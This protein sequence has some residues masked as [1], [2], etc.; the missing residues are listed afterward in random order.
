MTTAI[1]SK[2]SGG[3]IFNTKLHEFLKKNTETVSLEIV[4]NIDK[5]HFDVETIYIVDGILIAENINYDRLKKFKI[6][7][8]IHLW[9][10]V[11]PNTINKKEF[12]E[13]EKMICNNFAVFVTGET[14]RHH[15]ENSLKP[16]QKNY[17]L[18]EPGI[19]LNWK[20]KSSFPALPKKIIYL[21]NYIAGKGHFK[22]LELLKRLKHLQFEIHCYGEILADDYFLKLQNEVEKDAVK[23]IAFKKVVAHDEINNLLLEYDLLLHF[24]DYE[25]YGMSTME[26]ISAQLPC[27]ITPTGNYKKY[28]LAGIQG[29]LNTFDI[30]EITE[31]VEEILVSKTKYKEH[32]RSLQHFKAV[33]W[34]TTFQTIL[35]KIE[36]L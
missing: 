31:K 15:I 9:P 3:T 4:E 22:L 13:I 26:A 23:N 28:K 1:H 6:N 12:V 30:D 35:S 20:I 19:A 27:I 10:S 7:F 21:S 34:D 18:V 25:S 5:C 24:S 8:L 36:T 16:S 2:I 32:I 33:N 29:V 14:S 17:H 11:N